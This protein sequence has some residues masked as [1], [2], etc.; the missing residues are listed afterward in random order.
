MTQTQRDIYIRDLATPDLP[1]YI[2]ETINALNSAPPLFTSEAILS[3]AIQQEGLEDFGPDDFIERLNIILN[4]T[5]DDKDLHSLGR[6]TIHSYC[7]KSAVQRLRL[8]QLY[9]QYPDIDSQ[10]IARPIIIA[11]L[12][13]SGTTHMVNMIAT[14][15]RLRS[16]PY[17]EA[18]EPIPSSNERSNQGQRE[19]PRIQR[20][21]E[22]LA[23][24]EQL[25]PYFNAM[26][27]M[28][29]EYI[30]E[31]PELQ[32]LDFSTMLFENLALLPAWRDYYLSHDQT[33]H[34]FYLKKVLMA[35]QWLRGPKCWILKSPQHM[36]Q[37]IPLQTVFPDATFVLPHRDPVSVTISY[38]YMLTY[39]ARLSRDPVD[40]PRIASY[41]I[42][43][44]ETLLQRF[45]RQV[46]HLP[47]NQTVHVQFDTFMAD[48]IGIIE[49]IYKVADQSLTM[50]ARSTIL[51]YINENPRG[52]HGKVVYNLQQD[53][54]INKTDLYHRFQFY[55]EKFS[56]NCEY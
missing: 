41:W 53:F 49:K 21:R 1:G 54:G 34:Y 7:I 46:D 38:I 43:R 5:N 33:P 19:D 31:E 37:L 47:E 39:A 9:K 4:A 6:Q 51:N 15:T 12:P 10:P 3:T 26:H 50:Q 30:H 52:K 11:G 35:L 29:P 36:E 45:C 56:L 8:E 20:C 32:Y 17:W 22:Q 28:F 40:P 16:L 27:E 18:L 25:M 14:D 13:R 42:D 48:P 2:Q 23:A 55:I 24:Q 44:I